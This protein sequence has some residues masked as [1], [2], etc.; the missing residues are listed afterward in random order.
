MI[1]ALD[2]KFDMLTTLMESC[3]DQL[4][5]DILDE[6]NENIANVPNQSAENAQNKRP[7]LNE[8]NA[9]L[10]EVNA[11]LS[12]LTPNSDGYKRLL[13]TK[14]NLEAQYKYLQNKANQPQQ[15][16]TEPVEAKLV[17]GNMPAKNAQNPVVTF[18]M[19]NGDVIKAEL[20]PEIAPNTVNNYISLIKKSYYDGLQKII[21]TYNT[22]CEL[23]E[24]PFYRDPLTNIDYFLDDDGIA[25]VCDGSKATGEG[26]ILS[27]ITIGGVTYPVKVIDGEAFDMN[28]NITKVVIPE[29]I[30]NIKSYAFYYCQNLAYANIPS[31]V[32]EIG[33]YS[34][35]RK[36][37]VIG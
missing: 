2:M 5:I 29:S 14:Q 28:N 13:L 20:Y 9:K 7:D 21:I 15:A 36:Q 11:K 18:T 8:I 12:K 10:N 23:H 6:A 17:T 34:F 22:N 30:T 33:Q 35:I 4:N 24:S 27:E 25:H 3:L 19:E 26:S 1:D 31:N 37:K 16:K 32:V